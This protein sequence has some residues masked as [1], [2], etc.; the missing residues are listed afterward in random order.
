MKTKK[1]DAEFHLPIFILKY[2][3]RQ[4]RRETTPAGIAKIKAGIE[5]LET[6]QGLQIAESFYNPNFEPDDVRM[7]PAR[8]R[9]ARI[10]LKARKLHGQDSE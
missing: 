9:L 10:I 6:C 1:P 2:H 8:N 3:L 7:T 4:K 5:A